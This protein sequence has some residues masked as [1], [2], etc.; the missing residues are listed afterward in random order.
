MYTAQYHPPVT[1]S[2]YLPNYRREE[3]PVLNKPKNENISHVQYLTW[4]RLTFAPTFNVNG[5][6]I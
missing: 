4:D 5:V 2:A 6:S 1:Q 3:T